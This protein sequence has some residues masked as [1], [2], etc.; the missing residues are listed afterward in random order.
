MVVI[1]VVAEAEIIVATELETHIVMAENSYDVRSRCSCC[2]QCSQSYPRKSD[3]SSPSSFVMQRRYSQYSRRGAECYC[4]LK[5]DC[6]MGI[7][8]GCPYI[9]L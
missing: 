7:L 2:H 6:Y 9:P 1:A 5:V 4:G 3:L 8:L